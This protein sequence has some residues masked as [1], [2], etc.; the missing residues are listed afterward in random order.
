MEDAEVEMILNDE[1]RMTNEEA[2]MIL[3]D[4]LND[5]QGAQLEI[6]TAKAALAV[7]T[8]IIALEGR[9]GKWIR[10]TDDYRDYYECDNCG[11]AVGLDDV[12]DYCPKCGF[13][14]EVEE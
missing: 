7:K 3:E 4:G 6:I 13:K 5:A 2:V 9:T 12:K 11:I 1:R 14:M 8:A 10:Q